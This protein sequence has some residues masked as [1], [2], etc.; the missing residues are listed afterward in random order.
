MKKLLSSLFFLFVFSFF[1]QSQCSTFSNSIT[2]A[3]SISCNGDSDGA[4][5]AV[6]SG[7]MSPYSYNWNTG[8]ITQGISNLS[9]GIYLVTVSYANG[10][11]ETTDHTLLEPSIMAVSV[12]ATYFTTVY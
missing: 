9:A 6:P 12:S 7:G 2:E 4:L 10:C 8:A 11:I 1:V 3:S 5:T